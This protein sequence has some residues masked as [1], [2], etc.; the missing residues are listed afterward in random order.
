L[1]RLQSVKIFS[2]TLRI[3]EDR[4]T[5]VLDEPRLILIGPRTFPH[6]HY[7]PVGRPPTL[8]VS[9]DISPM[10]QDALTN[11]LKLEAPMPH[12]RETHCQEFAFSNVPHREWLCTVYKRCANISFVNIGAAERKIEPR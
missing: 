10:D 12:S 3:K 2:T 1:L 11:S 4:L 7:R 8:H 6:S 5:R 9:T